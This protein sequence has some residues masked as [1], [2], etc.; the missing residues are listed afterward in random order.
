VDY[1]PVIR[2][3]RND[4]HKVRITGDQLVSAP[5]LL[6]EIDYAAGQQVELNS[7]LVYRA[8]RNATVDGLCLW[9][10]SELAPDL[11]LSSGP[12]EKDTIY[13]TA[14]LPFS[15]SIEVRAGEELELNVTAAV[16]GEGYVWRW[17]GRLVSRE[18]PL[19]VQ[20]T[21]FGNVM[22]PRVLEHA[23][24][25]HAPRENLNS[26]R[27]RF[28]LDLVDGRRTVR[29]II[30]KVEREKPACFASVDVAATVYSILREHEL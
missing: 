26:L 24:L 7:R 19:G 5:K 11:W 4:L 6:A 28:V 14:L 29:D 3:L 2:R 22:T 25:D 10:D 8:E 16:V 18:K 23:S 9:F 20:S 15:E 12:Q 13:G 1:S 17:S 27:A 21:F 30:E